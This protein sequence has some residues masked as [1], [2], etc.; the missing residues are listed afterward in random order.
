MKHA[1][2]TI[3]V[4]ALARVASAQSADDSG[5]GSPSDPYPAPTSAPAPTAAP[6]ETPAPTPTPTPIPTP[7]PKPRAPDPEIGL[8]QLLAT[9][10]G[11]LLPAAVLYSRSG[12]DTAGG[13]TSDE[14]V[15]LGDVAEFGLSTLDDVRAKNATTDSPSPIQP[16]V[17]ATFRI[18]VAENR[19]FDYQPALVLGFRKSF[20]RST[21]GFS[22]RVAELSL[23][24]SEHLGS[25]VALHL[26]G[27]FWDASLEGSGVD[28]ALSDRSDHALSDQL[29]VFGGFEVKPFERSEIMAD[30]AWAPTFCYQCA[31]PDQIQ[32]SAQLSWGVRYEVAPWLFLESGVHVFDIDKAKLLDAQIFG[33]I[34]LVTWGLRH[35]FDSFK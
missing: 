15:G 32:L 27:S 20:E 30:L 4:M 29:R 16:Y 6:T 26:G 22:S 5:S 23:V 9:P 33:Q 25:R 10:T 12:L 7:I 14:R 19:L 2:M 1:F 35:A 34:T 13:V 8:P 28:T 11:W 17:A 21:D 24:A 18:G 31:A 3:L